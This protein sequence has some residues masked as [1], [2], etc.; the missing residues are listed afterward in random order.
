ML[1]Y[2]GVSAQDN[3]N[4][5]I[6]QPKEGNLKGF[7]IERIDSVYF[8][9]IEGRV[10]ADLEFKQFKTG[11]ADTIILAVTKTENCKGYRIACVPSVLADRINTDALVASYFDQT[12]GAM[13]YDDFTNAEMTGFDFK[14]QADTKYTLLTMGY[15]QYGIACSASRVSFTTP[16]AAIVGNPNVAYNIDEVGT[17]NVKITFTPN[18]DCKGY[19]IC[20]FEEGTAQQQFEQWGPMLG[21]NNMG[22]MIKKFS[23]KEY[24]E[25]YTNEWKDLAPGKKYEIYVQAWDVNNVY[26][27]M[28]IIP[29]MTQ[30]LGGE[31]IAEVTI[32]V[33]EFGGEASTG[34]YQYVTYTPNDQ[35]SLHRDMIITKEAYNT[36]EWGEAGILN[37]LKSEKNPNN[38]FDPYWDQYG[39][40]NAQWGVNVSTDYIAFSIAQ[41]INGEWGPLAKQEFTTPD[42][43]KAK[44]VM[45]ALGVRRASNMTAY[46]TSPINNFIGKMNTKSIKIE[47]KQK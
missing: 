32:T 36:A 26:A 9:E 4:R 6:I 17:D 37:Y 18:S 33:G 22:D 46:G 21:F 44:G 39:V 15:D 5:M 41:N 14:F 24:N 20:L 2:I 31:G 7:L 12:A 11:D 13:N 28:I 16:K 29:V 38:P 42:S 45:P 30:K 19:A 47:L 10:A 27:D 23:G 1:S 43:A 8:T 34:Y 35:C 40:D 3:P 25:V